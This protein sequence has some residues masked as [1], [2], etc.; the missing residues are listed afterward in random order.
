MGTIGGSIANN[1]PAADYPSAM[2]ALDA[3]IITNQRSFPASD[4]F[5]GLFETALEPNE[6]VTA[7][8]FVAPDKAAYKK[9]P[10]PASLYAMAGVFVAK[11]GD[12][13]SRCCDRRRRERRF[14]ARGCRDS[15][16][17]KL[18]PFGTG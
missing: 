12:Q 17:R 18:Q 2:L 13:Y 10:N 16:C 5:V 14:P 11:S 1:D 6:I 4:F 9:F 7:V 3:T 15:S 8:E